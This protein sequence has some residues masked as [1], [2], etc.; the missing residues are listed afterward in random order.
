MRMPTAKRRAGQVDD[1]DAMPEV[2][3]SDAR[4]RAVRRRRERPSRLTLRAM[5]EALGKTQADVARA[6]KT[7][8]SE[9]SRIERRHNVELETLRRFAEALGARCEVTFYFPE[10]GHRIGVADPPDAPRR[11]TS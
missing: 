5:R 4:W 7:E 2:D 8:Q 10:T 11:R 6:L 9:I 1:G 3:L